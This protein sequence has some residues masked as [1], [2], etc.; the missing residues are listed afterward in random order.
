MSKYLQTLKNKKSASDQRQKYGRGTWV[1]SANRLA[2]SLAAQKEA[3]RLAKEKAEKEYEAQ[4]IEEEPEKK[5]KQEARVLGINPDTYVAAA[6]ESPQALEDL[7]E[8][9]TIPMPNLPDAKEGLAPDVSSDPQFITAE[10]DIKKVDPTSQ[11]F[12]T[13]KLDVPALETPEAVEA[14]TT[15][16]A[17][18]AE[19][20]TMDVDVAQDFSQAASDL[21]DVPTGKAATLL[22]QVQ[23]QTTEQTAAQL[24]E[25]GID[26]GLSQAIA[27]DPVNALEQVEG[28]DLESQTNIADLPEEALITTQLNGLLAG[29]EEGKVPMWAQPAVEQVN[30]MMAAR[31]LNASTLGRDALFSAIVQSALPLAESNAQA[32]Q[33]RASEKLAAAVT[34]KTQ[35][36][37]FE[38]QMALANLSNEQQAFIQERNFK[39]QTILSNQAANNAARQFNASSQQQADQ[40]MSSLQANVDQFN[41]QAENAMKQFN[42]AEKNKVAA[43]QAGNELQARQFEEQQRSDTFKFIE[44]QNFARSSWNAANAQAVEQSNVTWRRN[45]NTAATA[46]QNAANQLNVQNAY[47][48]SALQQTQ[49][50]QQLRDEATYVRSAYENEEQRKTALIQTAI[51]QESV[52]KNDTRGAQS[53][54][55]VA[56]WLD[57]IAA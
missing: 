17:R 8:T 9:R 5:L 12:E 23:P 35:E 32:L 24:V 19:A 10:E 45:T 44:Q 46:A 22:K 6:E 57:T 14:S 43:L 31:G 26:S 20:A 38:Q 41:A 2:K 33:K 11:P 47:N 48:M 27:T 30:Q 18:E 3:E 37:E 13:K 29:M 55:Q 4:K 7:L 56:K 25:S 53:R 54:D 39:Q 51:G 21:M 16:V 15:P 49:L 28:T 50:W 52:M 40:F 34:F 42:V 36:A 1:K